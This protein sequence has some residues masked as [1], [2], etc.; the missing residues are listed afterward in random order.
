[1][2]DVYPEFQDDI[3]LVAVGFGSS[4]TVEIMNQQKDK[5]GFPGLFTEGPDA[6]VRTFSVR[7]Q[8]TKLGIASDGVIQF[9]EG[10]GAASNAEWRDRL[11]SL[12]DG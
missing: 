4:Q 3:A 12:L 9:K 8:S 7:T 5:Q 10:Y 1:M 11:Q 2:T 6:M